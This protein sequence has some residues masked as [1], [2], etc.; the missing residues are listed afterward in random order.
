MERPAAAAAAWML[1][2]AIAAYL[3]PVS[4]QECG[5]GNFR[6]GNGYC[7]PAAWR[8]D[9]TR[10]CLDDTDEIGCPPRTCR[11]GFF[12]CPAEQTCIPH[13]WVCDQDQDC[14]DGA[15]ERQNCP[16]TTCSSQQMTCSN[17]QC[18]PSEYRC[19]HVNDCSDGSDE[20][21]CHYPTCD[22]LT[23]ANGA[24]YNTSQ[25]CDQKID[26]RDSSD[27]ANC[28]SLCS[29]KEFECGSGECI[30]RAYVCDHDN[31]CE[32]N[33][34]E[35]NCT[36]DTCGGHQFTCSNGQ[37]INQNWV[38]DGDDDCQD[39]GDEDG[40]E[41]DHRYH[42][43][44]PREWACPGSG[45]CI[46][47]D[48]VCDGVPDCPD[49]E[50][51]NN[52]TIGRHCSMG[53]CPLLNCE[54]QCHQ[55]PFGGECFCPPSH[56]I[57]VND[58]RTC[59]DF[60]DC[61][62]W[63]IC[64]QKCE[65][66]QGRHRC[67][68]EEGYILEREQHCKANDT[69]SEASIIFSNGRDLL[70]GDLHGRNFRI[71]AESKNRGEAMG[72]D[73]HYQKRMVF[74]T[75]PMHDK[76]FS[77][78]I[79]GLNTQEILNVSVEAPENLAV[80]WINNKLYLV[81]T[82]VNRIDVVNLDGSQRLTLITENL[83]HPR[84]IALDPTVGYLFFSDWASLSGQ[85]KVE[86]AFM[87]GSNRK[88]LVKTKLG[89]PAGITLDLVS[90]RVYWVDSRYDYIETVTYDGVQRK[91]VARGGSLVPH[92][93]GISLFE[94]HVFFTDW[95][96][97]AVMKANKFSETNPQVYHQSNLRPYGV[98]V[99]HAL[100]QPHAS[101]PCGSNNGGCEQ[102]CVLSHR[103]DNDGLGYRCKC[104][105]G[106][107]LD[108]D[109]RH[110]VAVRNF[111]LFSS[112]MAVRGIPFTLSTQEDVMV[113]ITGSP[114]SFIGIDFDAQSSTIFFSDTAKDIIYKQKIDG[115]GREVLV[116]NRLGN[117]ES[118]SFDWISRNLY[119]TDGGIK[120]V[121]VMR[122]A[123][124]SRR[125]IISNLNNPRSIVVH[126]TAGF[127]FF[128]EWQRPAKIMRAW[129]D[130]SHLMPIVNTSL[131]WPN[132][133]AID[134][135]ASRLY[136]VDAFFDK[137]EHSTFDGLD[138]KRLGHIE[139]MT[140]PFGLTIFNDHV[141]VT[142]WRLGAIIRVRKSD[143]SDMT[144]IRSGINSVMNVKAYDAGLQT[145]SNYCNQPTHPN[146]DCSHLC[147]PAPNF[148]RLCGC[149]YGMKLQDNH[150]TCEGDPVNEPPTQQC[151]SY[152]F[153]CDNGKCVPSF[154]RCDGV[155]DCHDNSDEHQCGTFN[156]SC[157]SWAFTCVRGGQCI[158][159][160]WRCD[161]HNDCIDGSDE[162]N[163]PTSTIST[164]PP[165]SF[166]CDNHLCIPRDWVCDT[167]NDCSDGSDEKN[168]E[169]S[170]TCQPTQFRCPDHRCISPLYVCDGDKDCVDGSDEAGCV[171]NCTSSQ[172]KC[173]DGSAC[174]NSRYRC[175]GVYDCKDN[176]DEA[177]CPTRPPG[178]CHPDEFQCQG[179]GTCIPNTW[180]CDRHS[181]CIDGSDEHNGCVPKTCSP[182]QF[183]CD[184][185][186]CIY[187]SWICDGDND[188]R[189]MSDEKDCPTPPF[190]CPFWQWQCPG[191]SSCVSLSVL[192]DGNFDCPNGTD[193]S[194]LCNQ[195]S[196]SH[197]NGGCTH[198]C[199][200]GPFGATCTCPSGYQ[201]AND[202][203][204]CEDINECD[205]PGFCSQHC[206]N[207]RGSFRCACDPEYT[208]ESDGRSCKVTA[209]ENLMLVVASRDKIIVDNITAHTHNIYSLVQDVS[210]VVAL[211]FDSVT[212][213]VLWSDLQQGKTW[214]VFQN[215][216]DQR[217]IHESG[218][219]VTETVAVDWIGRNLYWTDYA[220][221]TIEVSKIDGSHRT[222]LISKNV[223]NPRGLAL[224]PRT[225]NHLMF[226]SD[227]GRHPRIER[228]SMD[229]TMRTVIVQEKIYWPTGLSIDY[230]NRLIYFMDAYLDYIEFCDYDGHNRRQVIAS[231]LILHHP[232]AL[233][234]FEDTM[235]WTDRGTR[236]VMQAN[237]WHGG[238][239]SVVMY[240]VH[241]PLGIIAIHPSRQP[242][243]PNPC[244]SASC[245]HLCLLSAQDPRHYSCVC[246]SGWNLSGDSVNCVR[247]DQ[248]F[249][250]SVRNNIIFGIS[251]DPEVKS[252][253]AM[254]PIAGIQNGFDVEFDDS[255]QF[256]Y[257]VENPGQMHRVKTDGS[258]RTVFAPLSGLGFSFGLALDWISRNIY[259]TSSSRSIEV[260]T[261]QGETRYGKTL[262]AN[263]GTSLGVGFPVGIAVDPVRG[264]LYWSDQGTDSGVPAKI[265]SADMDGSSLKI[266]FTGNLEHL[267]VVTLDIQEQKLYWAVTSRGVIER[268]NVDGTE[269]M[270]LVH[271]LAHPWGLA[272][273]G[274]FLYYSD[275]QYEVIERVDKSSG[276]NKVVLRDNVQ[277]LRGLR[278]YHRRN[279]ADS[280]NGCSNNPH[281]CQQ[282]CL[283]KPG[284]MSS[285]ACASGFKLNP[286]HHSCSPYNS[287]IVVS[288][289][290]VIRGFSLELSDH[291]EAMVPV[292]GQG[293]NVLHVDVDVASGFIYWCDFSSSV[294]SSNG[295][296]RIKPDGSTFSNIVTYGIGTNGIRGIAVDWVAGNLYFTN[297][298]VYETLVEVLRIN[299]TYR[300][301]LLKVAVDMPRHIVVDPKNR[302]LFWADYGQKPKI[303]RSFLDCTNRT[304]LVSEG[305]V[306][307]RGLAMDHSTGYIY[308]VDDSLDIIARIHLDGGE[309]Q[310]IR[311]GSRYPT[312]Y[313]ITVFGE[314]IIWVDRNLKKIFQASKEPGNTDPPVV[315]R[316]NINLLRDVTIFDEHVQPLSPAELNNNPCLQSNGGCSHFCFALPE[317]ST[318]KCGCAFGTLENDG[319]TCA[320]SRTDFLIYALNN[321]LRSLHFDPEDHSPP[322]QEINV[323]RT[324]IALD[325][326]HN[327]NRIFYTQ[328][329]SSVQG[330]ISYVSLYSGISTPIVLLPNI[331]IADGIAFDW[332]NRRIYYS[333]YSNQ[334][335]NSVA[336]DGSKRAVVARVP[337]PRAIV[338]DPCRGYMYWTDWGTNAKIERATLAGNFRVPIVNTSLVWPNGLTL[339]LE[340]DLL[341]WADAS[342]QKIERSTLT[343]TNREVIVSTTFHAFGLTVYGQHIY[344][345]DVYTNKIY[346]ANKYDGSDL[347]AM[348]TRL[349]VQPRGI[350]TVTKNQHAQCSNPCDRF[351]G[352]C[353]HI[354]APGP[355]GAECQCPHEGSWYLANDNKHCIVDTGTRCGQ[356]QF[357]CL[358]GHCITEDWKC[359]ND[360]DCGDGSDELET[361]CAF[362]TCRSTAFTCGNGR[363]VPY[364]YRCDYY[365]D[366]GDNSDEAGCL[367]RNCNS[368]TEFTCSNGRCIPLSSVC[369]GINNCND[370]DTSDEKNCPPRTCSS[371]HTKCQT[372][373]I[374]VPR[375][376]LCDGDND[377]G[378]MSDENPIFCNLQTCRSTEFQCASSQR[379][380]PSFWYCDGEADCSDSS[381]EPDSCV[382][383]VN[384]CTA[385]Q[386]QCDNGRCISNTWV[387][388]DDNDCGD[389]SDEDQRH[390][391]ELRN[392]STSQFACR[393]DRPPHRRCI[394]QS[395]VCD[396]DADCADALDEL[397]NCTR[398]TCSGG[399]FTCANGRCIMQ[400]FRCDRRNDCGDYSDERGCS[401]PPC[402]ADQFTCQN[403]RCI[404]R[405]FVCDEDN[406]CGDGSDEQEH[407]C[408]TPEPTC[409]PHQFHC[410]NGHCIEMG[411]VCNHMDDCSD[412][413]DEKGCGIN[414]CLDSSISRCDHNCTDTITSF[415]CSCLPG[416]KLMSDKRTC[417]D[418]DECKESPQLC[419]QKCENV[420]GS[421]ICKCAPGYIR[422]PDG[423]T[424]R[425]NSNIEPY[426]IFSNRYYLRNLT[427]DGTSYSLILQGL[428]NVVA[429]DFDRVEKRLYWIDTEK[430][431]IERMF[432][433][434]TNRE[435][436]ISHRLR[437]AESLAVDW[438]SRKLYW[439][440]AILDCLFVSDLEGRHRKMLAQHCVDANNTFCFENP[441]GIVLHPQNGHVYWADWGSRAYIARAG[442]DGANKSVIISTKI[443][444]PNAI[445]IDY[446]NDLL[447]WAD[448]HLGYIE[449]S[450][451][452]GHHRQTVYDGTLPHP[453]AIT[454][455]EDTVYWTDWNTRTVE[456]GNKYDGSDR[457]V[458]V[459]T[460]H[461][462]FDIHVYHP[463]RQPIV[464]NPCGTNNGGCSHL[465][466][467]KAGGKG[468][469]CECPD[470][471]QTV[472]LRDRTLCMPMCSSTQFLCGNNEKCIPIWWKCDGQKDCLDGS[473]E[474]DL[475]PHRFCRLGQFQCRDGNCT[476]PQ[477]LCNARQD[478]AD[479]SDEDHTLCEHHRCEIN[480]WQCA[481]KRCIPEAWQCDS[482]NDCQDNSDEDSSHCAS[483]TCK[484]GQ[485]RCNNGRCIPQ[486][487]KCDVDNDCGDYSDEPIQECMSAAYNCDNHTEFSCKTNYRCI[488]KWAVCNGADDCRDNSDEQGCEAVPCNPGDFRCR[489]HHCIPLRWKCDA[490]DDC[491]DNSDEENCVPRECTESEFRCADQ[492]CIPSRW[493]CDQENDCGDNSD[494]RDCD[495][496]TCRPDHFQCTS[497]HCVPNSFTCDGR[498]DCLDASDESSCPTRFPNGTYC[499]AAMFECKNHV[500]IQSF[501]ICDGEN[502]CVD[503]SDEELHLCFNVPCESPHR[504]RCDN[505]RCIYGHQLCN[506]VD[507]CGDGTDEKEE[508]CKNPTHK[509]CTETE[510]KCTN[511][512]CISEHY[513]CDNVDDCGDLSDETGCNLG[514]NRTCAENIC[515]QNCTQLSNGGF[516]CSCSPGFKSS[517][518]DKNSCQDIN[519]CE[520]FG[521]CPQSC[522]N[523]KG[524]YECFCADG[525]KSMSSHYGERCAANENPPLLLLPENVRIRKYNVS[526]EKFSEYLEEEEHIQTLDYDWDPEGMDLSVVYYTVLGQGSAFGAIKRAYIPDFESGSNN[527]VRAVDLGL[528]YVMQPDGL[529]VDWIG[530]HIYWS[531]AKSQRIEVATLDGR[532]RKW[533][534]T[535]QLDQPAAIVVNPKLGL[536][537]WTDQGK[538]PK[539][540][541]AWMNGEHRSVLVSQDLGWPNGLSIDYL[542]DDRIYWSDSKEDVIETIKY[543]GTDRR[544]IINE[545]M[546]PFSLD[547][548]EDQLYW[549]AKEKGEVWRQNK[550][551]KGNKEKVLVV[552]PWLTQVRVFHQLRYNQS[553]SN[554]CKQVCS[555][556]CL[557]RPG[558]YSCACPQGSGFLS[559]STVACDAA[560]ELPISMP[561]PCR[562]MHGGS[563]YFEENDLPKCKCSS[564]Y[565]GDY[566]EVGL[567]RG[568]PPGTTMAVLLT[569]LIITIVGALVLV[570]FFHYRKT[571]SLLPA[572]PKLPSLSSLAK[573]S[574]NGNGVTFRSGV[575][576]NMDI[577]VSPF[578]P[579][580]I[581]D[582]S[583][584]MNEHFVT[585]VGKQPVV[586]ENPTYA[587]KDSTSKVTLAPQ[588]P[589]IRSQVTV[590]ENV[591]NQNYGSPIDPS[592]IVPEPKPASPGAGEVQGTKWNI[593]KRKPKQTTNFENPIYAEMDSEQKEDVAVAPP[594]SPSL[595][596][597][598][599]KRNPTPGYS[600]TEDTFKDTANLVK[601]DSDV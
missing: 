259:Y 187:K 55:T 573:P 552:N 359:D 18:V 536:M 281:V 173:A 153:A 2:L 353:S 565:N 79:N 484:P 557:L 430:Q 313:G 373:N 595:P 583:M 444:W 89:W 478:C 57:N 248:P 142:D 84:G 34:D 522:R 470:D 256:I 205:S 428:G 496:K 601:E 578:G 146:G 243:S 80:D 525:F 486:S 92:P 321:S 446:T 511:G 241:Q 464:N 127:I 295:I 267:E 232:H 476:S 375:A 268:G 490:H 7:I 488:P 441:R 517:T 196:C 341:Y 253:D 538:E 569:F 202:T 586:F 303:E 502:D 283:P 198:Q 94:E 16:G 279:A 593:F 128:S 150:M 82:K 327:F 498:A 277:N 161:K 539:I 514:E 329:L 299:T 203:K 139:Q 589:S 48:K 66:R 579:E 221:E 77:T 117:V 516:V 461:R 140:H 129:S 495:M 212:G 533:L 473:D 520:Q 357:T 416:Y 415:Y 505:S 487:W 460:T 342:L 480:E 1:L 503:G 209:S 324:A 550:F 78:D 162:Q 528:K 293:R 368:T 345:T 250:M 512:H 454:L 200:Q 379:C 332:I 509:P 52:T 44:Y 126:P 600:A 91:T 106:F 333:D 413:S 273:H 217:A 564:G 45:R 331:G 171:L 591:E 463:Y 218:L 287:F 51:E 113:P 275:E 64:D 174:I 245:S 33:S 398:R 330:Q 172:F 363:C 261:L 131:G 307:P 43:C 280:S 577:S 418:I 49:G 3:A 451:L 395:W 471:F 8:C 377:C 47:I 510:Y 213:R 42:T 354:C 483:R 29:H 500:C 328:K 351:N 168:C 350:S 541:S 297:A 160:Q 19:D 240:S 179:D 540:E 222:V 269:R 507:D 110:C 177:G 355:N 596:A 570:S 585:E 88:D 402:H 335:I 69:F 494:E 70:I 211:D 184:N 147:Y 98:A 462:P 56:I 230:P 76:V 63:G 272:V 493:V 360:D 572:L 477:A 175:D 515:E 543:D 455:F 304:V 46:S 370:N 50:D 257:W 432:L 438:V 403:G 288:K 545:A 296:R 10:D 103:T 371:T 201:L 216:T 27:E 392:C 452:E 204:T 12:L 575:D 393:N 31:D 574:E 447:Y 178:M 551:G 366:C 497:G 191:S 159:I 225:G 367:F 102:V 465:C 93:F 192:C 90:K 227:W 358:N 114:S 566:C 412:N 443:E 531:D 28:T 504:F 112:K 306:T 60:D 186:N 108:T 5:S 36:Y 286:D 143:G 527:P 458:L 548:F 383:I 20:R 156:N 185:G 322:F 26:C 133:L 301:V 266:L 435:T 252:N 100:R 251:L 468:F 386:F 219:S 180:E 406:D 414:E 104:E 263:D 584:A 562:C 549:V 312:P 99:Y 165:T 318:P 215:G 234:L 436:I 109:E 518:L 338:V 308:W 214:S 220:L 582:R 39:S 508:H 429:L 347:I 152:S 381:D 270:I 233:T 65:N 587:A 372:T 599:S 529:A 513:V 73:F 81:E 365:D 291:S 437:R 410:D 492:Q 115:T 274:S 236:R 561:P 397:Q 466:L 71:L 164:C 309:S 409:P 290:S 105:F 523:S 223:T 231:D 401:Y 158:P 123:D 58:S 535:T 588:G 228:A 247:G 519:E 571:G 472:Q 481:N 378:D 124:K 17:G 434:K 195:D 144:V 560:S 242:S 544:L 260:I 325:Y 425:Q 310:V 95:T 122:L 298:F 598:T 314:S 193:E 594:P 255:E 210:F 346:R 427:T 276:N 302:Y 271:H 542:N 41:S 235:Y 189:D 199:I 249:L 389:M 388:D 524:S 362:H 340:S 369:N 356:S 14:S 125:Q 343:G 440:D 530:R 24:C 547:I 264:K 453:F 21:N 394:P 72:V 289:L 300:R 62:I 349:P 537:F 258:N 254:V 132:G 292:A 556:L 145:G 265:A 376:F 404:S 344:W 421:Y 380:I 411:K 361:V 382:Q 423:K 284:G 396:G 334:T 399:E 592:E 456:K 532:Y 59:T 419:S 559:G 111:L 208:L 323:E 568:I 391:C 534:I 385:N 53:N 75:D 555:H 54:Y 285:C 431:I 326:D 311:Y 68:C 491:G 163:C 384:S 580:T 450:D 138:R 262:I 137:I 118:L 155:D 4:G 282:I 170:G 239:Q 37:C 134:W 400:S 197:F 439:L 576:V 374:C 107:E 148:Q 305:I 390:H 61:Q 364:R 116:A 119:W 226:W 120:S 499:P 141:F 475:C 567:S 83:G 469:T 15:D 405:M 130:G 22:Q 35:H 149:P 479:G 417:V 6:C 30:L 336:E 316:D 442:M 320:T 237:K 420:I 387:C 101:N 319:K 433:N 278:V 157:S 85:P 181:D 459:N 25:K 246:P 97:L 294:R 485:F 315:I 445:T 424:C 553:V 207:M 426:L 422:E 482:V 74:W 121:S 87:D 32:D 135:S 489:N 182:S 244:A 23:C 558:G 224:D 457:A 169:A 166:T 526:S 96:K 521:I 339:D 597:K 506:G 176:S 167:D 151:G 563:C 67:L 449:F 448:A 554:P 348:T 501:W 317:L 190:Q 352:G 546:K 40:C 474:P 86:R 13:S 408:H 11:S 9:G 581:I 154:F 136:W 590:S 188:C 467:I 38:C 337:K 206:V 229:G 194:P 407:L 238:N 183:L